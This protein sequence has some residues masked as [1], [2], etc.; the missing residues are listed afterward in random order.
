MEKD[1]ISRVYDAS[2]EIQAYPNYK[3]VV[4]PGTRGEVDFRAISSESYLFGD[5]DQYG[6]KVKKEWS[7]YPTAG[8]SKRIAI[9][10]MGSGFSFSRD[11]EILVE[12]LEKMTGKKGLTITFS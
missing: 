5:N 3:G 11:Y 12:E 6:K 7:V 9:D 2:T 8:E 1:G 10:T 4:E